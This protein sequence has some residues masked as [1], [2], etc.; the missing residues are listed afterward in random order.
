MNELI[1]RNETADAAALSARTLLPIRPA[2]SRRLCNA[3]FALPT[4][5]RRLT[6]R[7][8]QSVRAAIHAAEFA[9]WQASGG[10]YLAS[11]LAALFIRA[12]Q[13]RTL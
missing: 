10:D 7:S 5:P 9:E 13:T 8:S 1:D 2:Q 4:V 11:S 6:C 3:Q 12:H